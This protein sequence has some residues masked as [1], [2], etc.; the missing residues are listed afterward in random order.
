MA[1]SLL[2]AAASAAAIWAVGSRRM[3]VLPE[4]TSSPRRGRRQRA[5][6]PARELPVLLDLFAAGTAGGMAGPIAF[7]FAAGAIAGPLSERLAPLIGQL[8]LGPDLGRRVG[9]VGRD[10]ELPDLVRAGSVLERSGSLGTPIAD[11]IRDLAADHRRARRRDAEA[12]ARRAPV[13]MLFPLVLLILPAFLLLTVVP[14]LIATL[15][16][17]S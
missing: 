17:L 6:S 14:L 5:G 7:R 16:S 11:A 2:G 1:A 3:T 9:D 13:R 10:L 8:S 12:R 4:A 15:G